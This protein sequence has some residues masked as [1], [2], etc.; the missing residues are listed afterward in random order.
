L[1]QTQKKKAGLNIRSFWLHGFGGAGKQEE[2]TMKYIERQPL[3]LHSCFPAAAQMQPK[4][5]SA[6]LLGSTPGHEQT[7]PG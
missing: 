6:P 3:P 7:E 1:Q 2:L 4:G 5:N